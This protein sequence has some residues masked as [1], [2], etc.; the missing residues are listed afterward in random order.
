MQ[1][2]AYRAKYA[3]YLDDVSRACGEPTQNEKHIQNKK[4]GD[5][6]RYYDFIIPYL[7]NHLERVCEPSRD[8]AEIYTSMLERYREMA[9][10]LQSAK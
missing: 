7:P 3:K 4:N 9:N 10:I 8:S 2:A 6:L 5:V 1:G